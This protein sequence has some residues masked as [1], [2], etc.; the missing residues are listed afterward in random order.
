MAKS[1]FLERKEIQFRRSRWFSEVLAC[2]QVSRRVDYGIDLSLSQEGHRL[3]G[4]DWIFQQDNAAIHK[5]WIT[6]NDFLEQKIRLLDHPACSPVLNPRENIL[7]LIVAK[8]YEGG[9]QCS[10]I[11]E[12][13]NAIL[14]VWEKMPS[15]QLHIFNLIVSMLYVSYIWFS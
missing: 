4:E 13:K 14:D 11:S 5:A 15:V 8:V 3:C 2:K 12:L 1:C 9:W 7:G 10:A 6:K